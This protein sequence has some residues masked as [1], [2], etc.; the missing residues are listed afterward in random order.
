ML[1]GRTSADLGGALGQQR[2]LLAVLAE[3]VLGHVDDL[4]PG[5]GVLQLYDVDVLGPEAG[6]LVGG[7]RRVDRRCVRPLEGEPGAVHLEGTETP[8][9]HDRRPQVDRRRGVAVRHVGPAQDDGGR[10]L[11]GRAEHVLGR[12]GR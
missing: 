11:V 2:L 5:V 12:A 3:A 7:P 9:P 1:T 10:T 4:G 6:H 8:G